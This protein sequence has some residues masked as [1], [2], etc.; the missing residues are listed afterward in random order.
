VR[1]VVGGESTRS[2]WVDT[3]FLDP[4]GTTTSL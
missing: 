3:S 1:V 2:L 4:S